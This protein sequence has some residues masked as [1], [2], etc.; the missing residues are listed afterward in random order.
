[1]EHLFN[2]IS[3]FMLLKENPTLRNLSTVQTYL[4]TLHERNEITLEDKIFMRP[5]FAQFGRSHGSIKIRQDYQ[6]MP[7]F[8]PIVDTASTPHSGI[9]KCLSSLLNPLAIYNY[10]VEDSFET[11]KCIKSF[12]PN[13]SS[14]GANSLLSM[15]PHCL[16]LSR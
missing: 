5:K 10:A 4:D 2:D 14:K 11:V 16:L 7:P 1:M 6:D 9:A 13:Y 12:L 15:S 8:R 3:K